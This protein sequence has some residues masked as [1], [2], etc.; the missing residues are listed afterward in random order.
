MAN[1]DFFQNRECEYFPCHKG[2][3]RE[4]FNCLFCFCP[5]YTLGG[6]CGGNFTHTKEGIKDCS[7]CL[8]PHR[9]ENYGLV[10]GKLDKV[11]AFVKKKD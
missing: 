11:I 6:D 2:A 4:N 8:I 7:G 5:L 10:T 1:Y 9:R 3:D